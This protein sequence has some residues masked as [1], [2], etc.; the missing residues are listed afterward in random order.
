MKSFGAIVGGVL[1]LFTSLKFPDL[2]VGTIVFI[3][4]G[5]VLIKH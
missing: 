2:I 3:I 5:R 1:V 4:V